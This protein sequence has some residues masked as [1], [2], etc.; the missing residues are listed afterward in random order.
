MFLLLDRYD[1]SVGL[2]LE[3]N[4]V[5]AWLKANVIPQCLTVLEVR[6]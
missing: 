3:I 2:L 1:W 5:D 6:V 4:I